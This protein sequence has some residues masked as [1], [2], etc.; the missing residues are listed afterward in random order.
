MQ[1]VSSSNSGLA[2]LQI[3]QVLYTWLERGLVQCAD[4]RNFDG[5][6]RGEHRGDH[7]DDPTAVNMPVRNE[8]TDELLM[9]LKEASIKGDDSLPFRTLET[10]RGAFIS[11]ICMAI[12]ISSLAICT[13]LSFVLPCV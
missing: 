10:G 4:S 8:L 7:R 13:C 2:P 5:V 6:D 1:T 9:S 11:P 12:T 3:F